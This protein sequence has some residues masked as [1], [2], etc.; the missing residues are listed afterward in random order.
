MKTELQNYL[1]SFPHYLFIY[2]SSG[3]LGNS[4]RVILGT[5]P[6]ILR[7]FESGG[8]SHVFACSDHPTI[9][10]PSH[11]KLLFSN[12]NVRVSWE[13]KYCYVLYIIQSF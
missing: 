10:H 1:W 9:I 7:L 2:L 11:Q 13:L 8:T 4:K 3:Q 12:V 5:K 6:V